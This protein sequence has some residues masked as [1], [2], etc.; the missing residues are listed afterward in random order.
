M[1]KLTA[2]IIALLATVAVADAQN[3]FVDT[4]IG[5]Y[6]SA[7]CNAVVSDESPCNSGPEK[8]ISFLADWNTNPE[9]R[10]ERLKVT[11]YTPGMPGDTPE[12]QL[13]DMTKSLEFLQYYVPI[14]LR[15]HK[16]VKA[17]GCETLATF[18]AV[19]ADTVGFVNTI[20]CGDE[21]GSAGTLGF[22]RVDGKWYLSCIALAG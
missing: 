16:T 12:E 3:V 15:A 17:D 20:E 13:E 2:I 7:S 5:T 10:K 4:V 8:F 19:S 6:Q 22:V 21:G 11:A 1:K 18:F 9:F 14:P